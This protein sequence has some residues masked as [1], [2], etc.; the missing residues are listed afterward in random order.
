MENEKT[1]TKRL[2]EI[3]TA[4]EIMAARIGICMQRLLAE[5]E[6]AQN[7]QDAKLIERLDK[8]LDIL[9]A[10]RDRMYQGDEEIKNKI[11]KEYASEVSDYYLGKKDNVR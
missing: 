10:E 8:E 7:L 5:E 2:A 6:K 11:Y 4:I 1:E 9:Y 3:D